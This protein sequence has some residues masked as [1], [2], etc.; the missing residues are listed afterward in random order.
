MANF[1]S[2]KNFEKNELLKILSEAKQMEQNLYNSNT[3]FSSKILTAAFFEP[4]TRT[5]LSFF[6]AAQR[7]GMKTLDYLPE[8]SSLKKGESIE[9]TIKILEGYSDILVIRHYEED[10]FSKLDTSIPLINAGNGTDEHPTQAVLDLYTI[11]KAFSKIDGLN[12]LIVGDLK[13]GRTVHSLLFALNN[14]DVSIKL[15][16]PQELKLGKNFFSALDQDFLKRI[17]Y[18]SKLELTDIDVLYMTRIQ[19]ERFKGKKPKGLEKLYRLNPSIL[20]KA[21]DNLIILHP[22][23]RLEEIPKEVDSTK[24]AYYFKQAKNAVPIRMAIIS[25]CLKK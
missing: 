3:L 12:F 17:S 25:Y 22:L 1:L 23:P 20:S 6:A 8:F 21:K 15:F 5:K 11:Q 10:I 19:Y 2:L 13:N 9:D 4:S 14:F 18:V 16:C 7:L 24:H